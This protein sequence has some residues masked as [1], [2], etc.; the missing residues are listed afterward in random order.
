MADAVS[1]GDPLKLPVAL[2]PSLSKECRSAAQDALAALPIV[3][4][5]PYHQRVT[6]VAVMV[7]VAACPQLK[8]LDLRGCGKITDAAVMAVAAACPQ[9][10]S[11][12]LSGSGL[13]GKAIK[14]LFM[15]VCPSRGVPTALPIY[16]TFLGV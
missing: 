10:T 3:R 8:S 15:Y 5:S 16:L 9:L 14:L 4:M 11:L 13:M 12:D 6:D 7:I 1:S 2:M